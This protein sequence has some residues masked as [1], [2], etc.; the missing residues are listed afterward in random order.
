VPDNSASP[1]TSTLTVGF[2]AADLLTVI[3]LPPA[4]NTGSKVE[5]NRKTAN[6]LFNIP[7]FS[8]LQKPFFNDIILNVIHHQ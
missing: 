7:V 8:F 3:I 1:A 2:S 4:A 5:Q 6:H